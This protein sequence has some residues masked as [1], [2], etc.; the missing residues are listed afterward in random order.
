M[1][2]NSFKHC[3]LFVNSPIFRLEASQGLPYLDAVARHGTDRHIITI[4]VAVAPEHD[5]KPAGLDELEKFIPTKFKKSARGT[6]SLSP[7]MMPMQSNRGPWDSKIK[8]L[9]SK[10]ILIYS[11]VLYISYFGLTFEH[12]TIAEDAMVS[13]Y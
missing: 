3:D 10:G 9:T 6:M 11:A 4:Q 2:T 1:M 7:I 8:F 12:V 5:A 13:S